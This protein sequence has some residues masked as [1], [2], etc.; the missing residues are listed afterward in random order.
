MTTTTTKAL[1]TAASQINNSLVPAETTAKDAAIHSATLLLT[2]LVQHRETNA[3]DAL[4]LAAIGHV[5]RAAA[6]SVEMREALIR[7]HGALNQDLKKVGLDEM[8]S[9]DE[10]VPIREAFAMPMMRQPSHDRVGQAA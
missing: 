2:M 9:K 3:V 5:A 6:L 8:Y 7:A 10:E 4:G 1:I